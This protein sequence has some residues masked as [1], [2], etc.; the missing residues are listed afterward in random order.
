MVSAISRLPETRRGLFTSMRYCS[1]GLTASSFQCATD[2]QHS[3]KL[4]QTY[5]RTWRSRQAPA[6]GRRDVYD[7]PYSVDYSRPATGY[8]S[9]LHHQGRGCPCAAGLKVAETTK[10]EGLMSNPAYGGLF[11]AIS[12]AVD[13]QAVLDCG[14]GQAR[15]VQRE[16]AAA[17]LAKTQE[18]SSNVVYG[19]DFGKGRA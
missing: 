19:I 13:I 8:H 15:L 11:G 16:R 2:Q 10:G 18:P 5:K 1:P 3:R 14:V 12:E 6:A 9:K 17:R 7:E 4:Q